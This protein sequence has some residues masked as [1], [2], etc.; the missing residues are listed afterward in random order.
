MLAATAGA[1][2]TPSRSN[3]A[4]VSASRRCVLS[5]SSPV[6]TRTHCQ[7]QPRDTHE[8]ATVLTRGDGGDASH[9]LDEAQRRD[10]S[11]DE[12]QGQ[13]A[14]LETARVVVRRR[15]CARRRSAT[16]NRDGVSWG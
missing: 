10:E 3:P 15:L 8:N 14:V 1:P 4:A 2:K 12:R 13:R 16:A 5:A 9:L 11:R 7:L 6:G